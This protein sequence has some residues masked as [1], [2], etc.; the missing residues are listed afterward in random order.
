MFEL[1]YLNQSNQ[2]N[3]GMLMILIWYDT[4]HNKNKTKICSGNEID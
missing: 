1:I 2:S 4:F 3:I